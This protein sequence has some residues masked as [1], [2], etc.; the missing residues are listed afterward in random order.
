MLFQFWTLSM[1]HT[2]GHQVNCVYVHLGTL[3]Q[4]WGGALTDHALV[5]EA[6][7][8]QQFL[9]CS[10]W[11]AEEQTTLLQVDIFE[12][13]KGVYVREYFMDIDQLYEWKKDKE[14]GLPGHYDFRDMMVR[15]MHVLYD[16]PTHTEVALARRKES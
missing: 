14:E 4:Y 6:K 16:D 2:Q 5:Q 15:T 8:E 1:C 9:Y 12:I 7:I 3:M 10:R 13:G 11:K